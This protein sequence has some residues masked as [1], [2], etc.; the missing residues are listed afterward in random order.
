M[1]KMAD[2]SV[3]ILHKTTKQNRCAWTNGGSKSSTEDYNHSNTLHFI[4]I[5]FGMEGEGE[6]EM[7]GN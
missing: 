6:I 5:F 1:G 3:F 7:D 2:S 4:Y